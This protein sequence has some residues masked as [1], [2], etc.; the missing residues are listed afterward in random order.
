MP[1]G[2]ARRNPVVKSSSSYL[3][4]LVGLYAGNTQRLLR[5]NLFTR[6]RIQ[7]SQEFPTLGQIA[8]WPQCTRLYYNGHSSMVFSARVQ[9]ARSSSN[10]EN[11]LRILWRQASEDHFFWPPPLRFSG[12]TGKVVGKGRGFRT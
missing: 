10:Q 7:V 9:D 5:P 6:L 1:C 3:S 4:Y 12:S 8:Y 2:G 11:H